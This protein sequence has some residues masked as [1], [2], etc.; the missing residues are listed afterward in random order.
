MT[1]II[2]TDKLVAL[3]TQGGMRNGAC[4]IISSKT[5]CN[6]VSLPDVYNDIPGCV[7]KPWVVL[8][9]QPRVCLHNNY[10]FR[11]ISIPTKGVFTS[12]L[13]YMD[14]ASMSVFISTII[15]L[16][17]HGCSNPEYTNEIAPWVCT[18]KGVLTLD[19]SVLVK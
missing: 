11:Y 9:W 7:G 2:G 6:I 1:V 4:T 12:P 8:T 17:V 15:A 3:K 10:H 13:G 14:V 5:S 18:T 19:M 16:G